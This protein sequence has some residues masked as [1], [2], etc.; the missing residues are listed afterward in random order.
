M[1]MDDT[2]APAQTVSTAARVTYTQVQVWHGGILVAE[3]P[4]RER[5]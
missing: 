2:K 1:G 3:W 4:R 5:A